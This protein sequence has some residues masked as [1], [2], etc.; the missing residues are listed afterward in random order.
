MN[1]HWFRLGIAAT[2][3]AGAFGCHHNCCK[4]PPQPA[5][6]V[7]SP[8]PGAVIVPAPPAGRPG[9]VLT[10]AP[11]VSPA[12]AAPIAPAAPPPSFPTAP[13]QSNFLLQ[14]QPTAP[15]PL[16][17]GVTLRLDAGAVPGAQ[18]PAQPAASATPTVR[19][20]PPENV[21][22]TGS[23]ESAA[24]PPL[25]VGIREFSIAIPERVATGRKPMLDGLDW[26]K[27]NGYRTALSM[28][29]PG[30]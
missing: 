18:P 15:A 9:E 7:A 23:R 2:G 5:A 6:V 19:L 28:R 24:T 21:P 27:A 22:A 10:P 25:P 4:N 3:M 16:P 20:L 8:P 11:I 14:P 26:L 17:S 1:T 30:E 13:V 12:P 29:R